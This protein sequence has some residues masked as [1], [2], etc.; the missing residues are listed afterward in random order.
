[1]EET[2]G[3]TKCPARGREYRN[4]RVRHAGSVR[5]IERDA[6]SNAFDDGGRTKQR[7]FH[8]DT[9]HADRSERL[10]RHGLGY[11]EHHGFKPELDHAAEFDGRRNPAGRISRDIDRHDPSHRASHRASQEAQ[12]GSPKEKTSHQDK[13]HIHGNLG[14]HD[15]FG[16]DNGAGRHNRAAIGHNA[17]QRN[18]PAKRHHNNAA[19]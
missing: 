15:E 8:A 3:N 4:S 7:A 9:Q 10:G 11:F 5:A 13:Q 19:R 2:Y 6:E 14:K 1:M 12:N 18:D 17:T 16:L